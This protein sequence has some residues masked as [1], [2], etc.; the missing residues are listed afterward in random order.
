MC[1]CVCMHTSIFVCAS[2]VAVCT[3]QKYCMFVFMCVLPMFCVCTSH[4][5]ILVIPT[6]VHLYLP[7]YCVC[8]F[9]ASVFMFMCVLSVFYVYTFGVCA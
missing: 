1:I 5:S 9:H 3:F 8:T 6:V 4:N 7:Y 2:S